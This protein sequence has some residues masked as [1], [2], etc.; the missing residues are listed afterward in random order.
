MTDDKWKAV[1]R[2]FTDHM[3]PPD[4]AL[5]AALR[6]SAV[7]ALPAISVSPTQGKLLQLLARIQGARR[8]LEIGTLGGYSTIW[9]ARAL[10]PGGRLFATVPRRYPYHP[11]PIDTLLRPS[12]DE[13]SSLFAGLTLVEGAEVRC[14]SLLA[15]FLASPTKLTSLKRGV[16]TRAPAE[17][18]V[19]LRES[20]RMLFLSTSVS[21]VVLRAEA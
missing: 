17:A 1:D 10:P 11:G 18:R 7:A 15:Y 9:L 19:P 13:L 16:R 14:E 2:Y 12:V 21:A 5:E 6:D 4:T 20:L 8:I 3:L